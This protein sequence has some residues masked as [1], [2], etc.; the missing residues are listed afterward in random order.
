M[1]IT[2]PLWAVI[3]AKI[4]G[5]SVAAFAVFMVLGMAWVGF[6]IVISLSKR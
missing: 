4:V 6:C 2:V 3:I 5:V 1:T